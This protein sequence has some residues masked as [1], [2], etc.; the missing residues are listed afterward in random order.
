[1]TALADEVDRIAAETEFSGVVRIDRGD[2]VEIAKA[3][4]LAHRGYAISNEI[5]TRF[6]IASGTKGLTALAVVSLVAEGVLELSTTARSLLGP[7]LPLVR[8]DVAVE[9]LLSHRSGIGDYFDEDLEQDL[10]DYV[11][12]VPVH[13]L[14][15]TEQ[16][17]AV[18]DGHPTKFS[19]GERFAYCNG[20]YVVL[21]LIAER[22]SSVPFHELVV[23]RVCGPAG[24]HD[25]AFLRS[26]ELPGT[27]ATGY[28]TNDGGSRTNVFHLP[29]RG[30]GDGGIYSTVADIRSLWTAFFAGRIV[31]SDWVAEMVRPR[32]DVLSQSMRYG[33][34]FWL[35]ASTEVV[36]LEG[37][38]AGVSFRSVH[39]PRSDVTH[40]VISNTTDG[41]WPLAR[42]LRDRLG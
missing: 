23:Q 10:T 1:V 32:S 29:V 8:E 20:G 31:P 22:A 11:L 25:T 41:A 24:M 18:L 30:S 9:H 35:H 34:G 39:D 42:F 21:A 12:P 38:D 36:V 26:D 13:E 7:D 19:P 4:G 6:A 17:L 2:R 33:L 40:T 37:M 28:L 3:Y 14:A 5:G 16:Y 15:A 27:A